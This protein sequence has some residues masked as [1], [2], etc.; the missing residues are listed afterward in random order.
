ME[1]ELHSKLG[2]IYWTTITATPTTTTTIIE[3]QKSELSTW[4]FC[5]LNY[6]W[7][8]YNKFKFNLIFHGSH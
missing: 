5:M 3:V 2:G 4:H 6:K 8:G 7:F 1:F